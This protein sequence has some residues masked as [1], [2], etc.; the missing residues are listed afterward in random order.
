MTFTYLIACCLGLLVGH[1][2]WARPTLPKS[3]LGK[4]RNSLQHSKRQSLLDETMQQNHGG[5]PR[6]NTYTVT[7]QLPEP[8][9]QCLNHIASMQEV[10]P[11]AVL[12]SALEHYA[13]EALT[14]DEYQD[15]YPLEPNGQRTNP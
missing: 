14:C 1:F 3:K 11:S 8:E 10:K 15:F 7:C 5:M 13:R 9:A 6:H 4:F 12:R 2:I